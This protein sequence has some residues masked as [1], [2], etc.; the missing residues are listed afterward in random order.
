MPKLSQ[1]QILARRRKAAKLMVKIM[2]SLERAH[3]ACRCPAPTWS[4]STIRFVKI[5]G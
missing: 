2:R 1:K 3:K 4:K 5:Y